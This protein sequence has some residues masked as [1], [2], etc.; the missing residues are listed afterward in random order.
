MFVILPDASS[1]GHPT[2]TSAAAIRSTA[3]TLLVF[4][5]L[6][7]SAAETLPYIPTTILL[8]GTTGSSSQNASD[9]AYIFTPN[10][11][12]VDL[13]ALNI[14][15]TLEASSLSLKTLTSSLPFHNGSTS[16]FAPSLKADGSLVVYAGDCSS[17][18]DPTVW[19]Y[20]TAQSTSGNTVIWAKHD[21]TTSS[22]SGTFYSPYF[23]GG[24]LSF[25]STLE[26][27]ISAAIIYSYGG[28]CPTSNT[29]VETWQSRATYS[30]QMLRVSP[31]QQSGSDNTYS[32]QPISSKGP[33][34]AEAGFT[35]TPLSPSVS[36][37]TGT[38]T[39]QV[40]NVLL[41]GHTQQAF[42]NM[43]T[44]AIWSLPEETWSFVSITQ[45]S[46]TNTELAKKKQSYRSLPAS[47]DSRSGHTTILNEDGN[48]LIVLGGWVGDVTQAA[49]PQLAVLDMGNNFGDWSWSIPSSQPS[50]SGIYGHGAVLLPGNVMLVYGG[51]S[52]SSSSSKAKRQADAGNMFLNLTAMTWSSTYT[53]PSHTATSGKGSS[54]SST[55]DGDSSK[56]KRI[57]LGVGLGLGI[58]ML[59]GLLALLFFCFRRKRDQ[60]RDSRDETVRA[61]AQ[62]ATHFL[63]ADEDEMLERDDWGPTRAAHWYTGGHD[64][65]VGARSRSLGYES[66]RGSQS[67]P[68]FA[69]VYEPSNSGRTRKPVRAARGL[70]QPTNTTT[71]D[72]LGLGRGHDSTS[73]RGI[74]PI[75]EDDEGEGSQAPPSPGHDTDRHSDPFMTPT[76]TSQGIMF[77]TTNRTSSSPSPERRR[78]HPE[79]QDWV[80]DIDASDALITAR[81]QPRSTTI[82]T[83]PGRVSPASRASLRNTGAGF[84]D[85]GRTDSNLS[86]SNRSTFSFIQ[87]ASIQAHGQGAGANSN[88]EGD[89]R[90]GSSSG[91]SSNSGNT[92]TTAKSIPT[93]Q[94]EGPSLLLGRPYNIDPDSIIGGDLSDEDRPGSPSKSKPRR[95]WLG[96]FRRVF[97]SSN[98]VSPA[99]SR[100]ESPTRS[101]QSDDY[102]TPLGN[103]GT[104]QRRKQGREA[105]ETEKGVEAG[106]ASD[107][108]D[109]ERAVEQ[110]LVQVMFTI[111]K[112]RLR[113]V[114]AEIEHDE[115][116]GMLV[117]PE[118]EA[119][120][121]ARTSIYDRYTVDFEKEAERFAAEEAAKAELQ[122]KA[123]A[124]EMRSED[125]L[126]SQDD[127][128]FKSPA[129]MTAEAVKLEKRRTKVLDMVDDI[130]RQSRSSSPR[131]P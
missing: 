125:Q 21:T 26:P 113:V 130:E 117:D 88:R 2:R 75:Y 96:S 127:S 122:E 98:S 56:S 118:N 12:S 104:L 65:Y 82:R 22:S 5:V 4:F 24:S 8:S 28:M 99:S 89:G 71:F 129:I 91:Q 49:D 16:T 15:A 19:S 107:D 79:V 67:G 68:A 23:L 124:P 35:F 3:L 66:L 86:E 14:S 36:N 48:A 53:N 37:R 10:D 100:T 119:S 55:S 93:L 83:N 72:A 105:W 13:L 32:A 20:T 70:Y 102:E 92:Y 52:I 18:D 11:D 131:V 9:V 81:I 121:R 62:D 30:N 57:G 123:K 69:P 63:H 38:V 78:H 114:N 106:E 116:Q 44:A 61:L 51:Y 115:D 76:S 54:S 97:S 39:Q 50:G 74:H 31:S 90:L 17:E 42:I 46:S 111:P 120:E 95:G 45:P 6:A 29:T 103:T 84:E 33:P 108:W 27:T 1:A 60:K 41:G 64:P 80:S 94:A 43:S 87:R 109:V 101:G 73:P 110:R 40:N 112:E 34:V 126:E 128:E 59:L 25:S 7:V 77:A 58:P 47:V 85:E